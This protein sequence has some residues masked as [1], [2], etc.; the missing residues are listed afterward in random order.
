MARH[1]IRGRDK[2]PAGG[3][4][5]TQI[6][7]ARALRDA[8]GVGEPPGFRLPSGQALDIRQWVTDFLSAIRFS[9]PAVVNR[10]EKWFS[11]LGKIR[12]ELQLDSAKEEELRDVS[13][14]FLSILYLALKGL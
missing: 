7:D 3:S 13:R 11:N 8:L 14:F 2:R 4:G 6:F 9:N 12:V 5:R 10:V 1:R